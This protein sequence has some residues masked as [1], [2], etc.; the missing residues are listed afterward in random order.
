[1]TQDEAEIATLEALGWI[2][3]DDARISALLG[4]TGADPAS[5]RLRAKEPEFMGF[6]WDFL[7]MSD[8]NVLGFCEASGRDPNTIS[9][10][11]AALPGGDVPHWT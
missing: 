6:I 9:E 11:R 8:E 1:M 10:I 5:L 4:A 7:M 3:Q 2:A